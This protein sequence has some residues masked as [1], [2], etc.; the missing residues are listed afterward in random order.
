MG[1]CYKPTPLHWDPDSPGMSSDTEPG[2]G[3]RVLVTLE[4][5]PLTQNALLLLQVLGEA[6]AAAAKTHKAVKV[7]IALL[8]SDSLSP[9]VQVRPTSPA[10]MYTL[11]LCPAWGLHSFCLSFVTAR[12][13][14]QMHPR[15]HTKSGRLNAC[16]RL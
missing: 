14:R 2:S 11:R 10:H 15:S 7:G 13:H 9:D 8:D 5:T 4:P 16:G 12:P 3:V 6:V 1:C